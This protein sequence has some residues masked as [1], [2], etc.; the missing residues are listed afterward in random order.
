MG[1]LPRKDLAEVMADVARRLDAAT[2][3]DTAL[4]LLPQLA[5]EVIPGADYAGLMIDGRKSTVAA[6]EYGIARLELPLRSGTESVGVLHVYSS[7]GSFDE[8]ARLAAE[9]FATHA[10]IALGR[11]RT[12][13]QLQE[14]LSTRKLIGQALGITMERYSLDEEHAFQLLVRVSQQGNVKL[15]DVAREIVEQANNQLRASVARVTAGA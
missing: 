6:M 2:D 13:E 9:L 10:G 14:A 8:D 15:R 11:A 4:D 12:E 3:A 1:A 5:C 7:S